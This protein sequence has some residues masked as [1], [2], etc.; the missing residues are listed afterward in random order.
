G[1]SRFDETVEMVFN[2]GIDP[3]QADQQIRGTVSL[4][5]GTGKQMRVLVFAQGEKAKEAQEAGADY[6]GGEELVAK[7]QDGWVDF[8]AAVATPDMMRVVGRLGKILGPRGLMPNAKT[9]TVTFDIAQT[10]KEIKAGRIE[11]R[12][13]RYGNVHLPLGKVSFSEEQLLD[14]FYAALDTIVRMKPS[15]AKGR[16]IKKLVVST[17]MSPGVPIDVNGALARMEKRVA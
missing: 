9:G 11:I 2:L 4:P 16:Y 15:A 5:H 10:V 13:D 7:I 8:D 3:K 1:N 14:N 17:T 12:N 6:V